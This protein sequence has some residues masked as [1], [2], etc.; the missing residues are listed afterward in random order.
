VV[1]LLIKSGSR[2][3]SLGSGNVVADG[4]EQA[5][6]EQPGGTASQLLG[7]IDLANLADG[8]T[9]IMKFYA[10]VKAN[11]AW[12]GCYEETYTGVQTPPLVHIVKRPE[13]HGLKITLQQ[14]AGPYKTFD[15]E[16]FKES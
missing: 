13:Y 6:I 11:G 12:K 15:Y 8:D 7:Y 3:I 9:I 14:T 5:L 10:K 1:S 2:L 16:F 4:S